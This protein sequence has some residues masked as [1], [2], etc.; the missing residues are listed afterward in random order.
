VGRIYDEVRHR[1]RSVVA[2]TIN[3]AA[4]EERAG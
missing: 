3:F 1:P 4:D 2:E